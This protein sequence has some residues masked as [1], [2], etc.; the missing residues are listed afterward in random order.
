[1]EKLTDKQQKVIS[2]L[3][4]G[5]SQTE[6]AKAVDCS[7]EQINRWINSK[8]YPAF[9]AA[10]NEARQAVASDSTQRLANLYTTAT[11]LLI[12]T[13]NDDDGDPSNRIKIALAIYKNGTPELG[14]LETNADRLKNQWDK[15]E[16][17][18]DM[19]ANLLV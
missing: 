9:V 4:A 19:L 8:K 1:M 15:D 14:D 11:E 13:L 2:L 16:R 18:S 7:R 12:D 6:A 17:M 3:I 5:K 10:L